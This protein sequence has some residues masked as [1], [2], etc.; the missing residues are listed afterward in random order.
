[1]ILKNVSEME[2]YFLERLQNIKF[3]HPAKI[4]IKGLAIGIEFEKEGY[5]SEIT[6]KCMK[7][8][9]LFSTLGLTMITLFPA[10]NIDKKTAKEGLDLIEK[11]L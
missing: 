5:A 11:C 8:G 4:N 2:K 1:M 7:N 10:L 3:K 9:L 6:S